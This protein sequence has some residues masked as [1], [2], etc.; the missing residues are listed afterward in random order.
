VAEPNGALSI[1]PLGGLGEV[2]NNCLLLSQS[3]SPRG[4]D[5]AEDSVLIDCGI[6]FPPAEQGLDYHHPRFDAVV[7]RARSLRAVVLTHGHADHVG[8]IGDL[9]RA[10]ARA[11]SLADVLRA[12]PLR[13][14]GPPYALELARRH[15]F[16][17]GHG[18]ETCALHPVA[19]GTRFS[20]G[21]F[22]FE[23]IAVAHSTVDA[24]ALAIETAAGVVVHS[25][26]FKLDA[27]PPLGPATDE[28]RLA[29][30]GRDGVTL[31]LSDS[32]N[33]LVAGHSGSERT[34]AG[35]LGRAVAGA[36]GRR[37]VVGLFSSNVHRMT[38]LGA[39]AREH[40][41]KICLLGRSTQSHADVARELGWLDWRS[42]LVVAPEQAAPSLPDR[43][44]YLAS[45]TQGE[46]RG[47]LGRLARAEHPDLALGHGDVVIVSSRV[48]P[49]NER[50]VLAMT[51]QLARLGC[52][53][54]T[55][56]T[57]PELHVSGHAH[58]D[59]QVR[60][61]ELVRPRAFVPLHGHRV[62]LERHAELARAAGVP[63][64]RVLEN[65]QG[66]TLSCEGSREGGRAGRYEGDRVHVE[67]VADV[68]ATPVAVAAGLEM[69]T[70][71][72]R[73]RARLGRGGVVFVAVAQAARET[74]AW[75]RVRTA[76]VGDIDGLDRE[77][78][79]AARGAIGGASRDEH[80]G[81][82]GA[83][84]DAA[85]ARLVERIRSA[86][87]RR[88]G[89]LVGHKPPVEVEILG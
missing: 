52:T 58:R 9:V 50:A 26:D 12:G 43:V 4:N 23:A 54:V 44:L 39:L 89:E 32:T 33:A 55:P 64:V 1:L 80:A 41:R 67:R 5:D 21:S 56:E 77:L 46:A 16:E 8:A 35:A 62:Q 84:S 57:D 49:G 15:L 74:G 83:E 40:G 60:L 72:L 86:V 19:P 37:I 3:C 2:G 34:V 71:L 14:W 22:R 20:A 27:A 25:G 88:A 76:G 79:R 17:A 10:F 63:E 78:E 47:A 61:I 30:L 13:V 75:L 24:T 59:E 45:G 53:L 31:L 28:A 42:D 87:R 66:V 69:G 38:A 36:R 48:I 68:D 73:E 82:A 85:R 51:S 65:G 18:A 6:G 11:G 81:R 29:A 7:A 70:E